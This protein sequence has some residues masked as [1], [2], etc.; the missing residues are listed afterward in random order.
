ARAVIDVAVPDAEHRHVAFAV[1]GDVARVLGRL[2]ILRIGADAVEHA[3][4]IGR[5]VSFDLAVVEIDFGALYPAP[6]AATAAERAG[7]IGK[8]D[9]AAAAAGLGTSGGQT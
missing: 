9:R 4:E 6:G 3:V 7:L 5:K 1:E 8:I 2:G